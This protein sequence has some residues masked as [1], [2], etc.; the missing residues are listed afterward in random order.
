MSSWYYSKD[1]RNI[2]PLSS[3]K[4]ANK[5]LEQELELDDYVLCTKT[6]LWK[7]IREIKE[8]VDLVHS[9]VKGYVFQDVNIQEYEEKLGIQSINFE[10]PFIYFSIAEVI[11]WQLITL[12]TFGMYWLV[13]QNYYLKGLVE[14][15]K[16]QYSRLKRFAFGP[17]NPFLN[18]IKGIE[19]H[20][21]LN[22]ALAPSNSYVGIFILWTIIILTALMMVFITLTTL[23]FHT[24]FAASISFMVVIIPTQLYINHCH[25][26]LK[27]PR[28]ERPISF[29]MWM[30][31]MGALSWLFLILIGRL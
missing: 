17:I 12:G 10:Q 13:K 28:S 23:I 21:T 9:P 29:Y 5:V 22:K 16:T 3:K 15:E 8:I 24:L 1:G 11:F 25:E 6:Q 14:T 31:F 30:I 26:K 19:N 2:G 27:I 4:I 7:R 20:K 18:V